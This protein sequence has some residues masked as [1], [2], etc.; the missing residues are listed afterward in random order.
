MTIVTTP[1]RCA[2][3]GC[4]GILKRMPEIYFLS[5]VAFYGCGTCGMVIKYDVVGIDALEN[6]QIDERTYD[7]YMKEFAERLPA[8]AV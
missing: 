7:E 2:E 6:P 1:M 8:G 5:R 3:K 4:S